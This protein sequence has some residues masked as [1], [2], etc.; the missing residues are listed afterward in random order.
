MRSALCTVSLFGCLALAA[1]SRCVAQSPASCGPDESK[2]TVKTQPAGALPAPASSGSAQIVL[3]ETVDAQGPFV[4]TNVGARIGLDGAWIGAAQGDSQIVY[5]LSPGEHHLCASW[6]GG[7]DPFWKR[8]VLLSFNADAGKTY[9]FRV[10]ISQK[11]YF[12]G[13][14]AHSTDHSL[15]LESVDPDEGKYL[16]ASLPVATSSLRK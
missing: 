16:A 6:P 7:D 13:S 3:L 4:D 11:Q 8:T 5:S 12:S 10:E 9:Y 15:R 1:G 14:I 2:F